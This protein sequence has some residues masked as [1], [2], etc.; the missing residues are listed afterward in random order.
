M[1]PGEYYMNY[2]R[3]SALLVALLMTASLL[4]AAGGVRA[5]DAAIEAGMIEENA[6]DPDEDGRINFLV[7]SVPVNISAIEDSEYVVLSG[8][9]MDEFEMVTIASETLYAYPDD[10]FVGIVWF[11]LEFSGRAINASGIDGPYHV[12]IELSYADWS[13]WPPILYD[14]EIHETEYY[15]HDE[16]ETPNPFTLDVPSW[17]WW[18]VD[19]DEDG[20]YDWLEVNVTIDAIDGDTVTVWTDWAVDCCPTF[21]SASMEHEIEVGDDQVMPLRLDGRLINGLANGEVAYYA[22]VTVQTSDPYTQMGSIT[23]GLL[24]SSDFEPYIISIAGD[25][26][27]EPMDVNQDGLMDFLKVYYNTTVT[28]TDKFSLEAEL[29]DPNGTEV[30]SPQSF[31]GYLIEDY[32]E[33]VITFI[34]A[35][36][37]YEERTL[38]PYDLRIYEHPDRFDKWPEYLSIEPML[39]GN[40]SIETLDLEQLNHPVADLQVSGYVV[41]E[42]GVP[43]VGATVETMSIDFDWLWE[44]NDDDVTDLDGFYMVEDVLPGLFSMNVEAMGYFPATHTIADLT[45]NVTELNITLWRDT[46]QNGTIMGIVSDTM[47]DPVPGVDMMLVREN[48]GMVNF[49]TTDGSG[50]Y[51]FDVREGDYY[52]WGYVE[53]SGIVNLTY[54]AAT[55]EPNS[56]VML[57]L[58]MSVIIFLGSEMEASGSMAISFHDWDSA[59]MEWHVDF[60]SSGA[61][62][63]AE[64]FFMVDLTFG[65]AD[66]VIDWSEA[67][68]VTDVIQSE[69]LEGEMGTQSGLY[70]LDLFSVDGIGYYVPPGSVAFELSD[71]TGPVWEKEDLQMHLSFSNG[72]SYW[73]VAEATT[74]DVFIE[75]EYASPESSFS[76]MVLEVTAPAGFVLT[77]TNDPANVTI[78]GLNHVIVTPGGTPDPDSDDTSVLV[79]LTF[80]SESG[81]ET[82]SIYGTAVLEDEGDHSGIEVELLDS[83]LAVLDSVTTGATGEFMFPDLE[84][85]TYNV[86]AGAAGYIDAYASA[87]VVAGEMSE[88]ELTLALEGSAVGGGNISGV[89]VTEAGLPIDGASVDLYGPDDD[90]TPSESFETGPDGAFEFE[91]LDSGEYRLEMSADGFNDKTLHVLLNDGEAKD[92]GEIELV[93]DSPVGYV[94]GTL[95][96][97]D[98]SPIAGVTVEVRASGSDTILADGDTDSDG[99]F[100][101][102]G[103]EDGDYNLTFVLDGDVIGHADVTVADHVGDVGTIVIDLSAVTEGDTDIPWTLLLLAIAVIAIVGVVAAL[104]MRKPKSPQPMKFEEPSAPEDEYL[105]PPPP[106]Y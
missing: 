87:E 81:E 13:T 106:D 78:D 60:G 58:T 35:N 17:T 41:D 23:T 99:D 71:V 45:S 1:R 97:I 10:G 74:H 3:V 8:E 43:V 28:R 16:F 27:W 12:L 34:D 51:E 95:Q 31:E 39:L 11:D 80:A 63:M 15:A 84:P 36:D 67:E 53:D 86:R 48:S 98:G 62:M 7:I 93:S 91:D 9:L 24:N 5:F 40:I 105:P 57:N 25:I 76:Q 85:G 46:P 54:G 20:L 70:S 72:A 47:G 21:A 79:R 75:A 29:L 92:L 88:V 73:P 77:D 90:S 33:T 82:G 18:V 37:I 2:T 4:F 56:T 104:K 59:A 65:N 83:D 69:F 94:T 38:G 30:L 96:D 44:T 102:V 55:V 52:V 19:D 14:T 100:M 101:I 68:L 42:E 64:Y 66:G 26:E 50:H 22:F 61:A 49:T 32:E 6:E 89:V 103:L